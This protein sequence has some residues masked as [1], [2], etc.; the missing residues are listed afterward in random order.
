M[1]EPM[2]EIPEVKNERSLKDESGAP[3]FSADDIA[4]GRYTDAKK[5]GGDGSGEGAYGVIYAARDSKL[6]RPVAL[7]LMK[8]GNM[9]KK[10]GIALASLREIKILTEFH[11]PNIVELYDVLYARAR[12]L[13]VMELCK[14]DLW[15]VIKSRE[16]ITPADRKAYFQMS[17]RGLDAM[18]SRWVIHRDIKP[19][20]IL[21]GVNGAAKL[22][23]FGLARF[24][25]IHRGVP[26]LTTGDRVFTSIY[27]P[28][29]VILGYER[30]GPAADIWS[31]GLTFAE[32]AI[33][34][35]VFSPGTQVE[36][37]QGIAELLGPPPASMQVDI[38]P[39]LGSKISKTSKW[40]ERFGSVLT[41]SELDLIS[42]MLKWDPSDR[43][44]AADALRHPIFSEEPVPTPAAFLPVP[45]QT[46]KRKALALADGDGRA[47][48]VRCSMFGK[49][50][51]SGGNVY[52]C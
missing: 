32:L 22:A 46:R 43:I 10:T 30:Y 25:R 4:D 19:D 11:H 1:D 48:R 38:N 27:R 33:K 28:P 2:E 31:L 34:C 18:H 50:T 20:N 16:S 39:Y 5:L 36:L 29:E 9:I 52:S 3:T 44:T 37:L 14:G 26:P 17:L 13:V 24:V 49:P 23:D 35:R 45:G 21:I 40:Q 51:D 41:T 7:K 6:D 47:K 15:T 42:R 12:I 8:K